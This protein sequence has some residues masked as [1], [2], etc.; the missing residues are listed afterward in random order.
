M[1]GQGMYSGG[2]VHVVIGDGVTAAAFVEQAQLSAG[3]HLVVIG[4]NADALGRGVAYAAET[5]KGPWRYAYL[6]NS[7]G[8]DLDVDFAK[9]AEVHWN[10]IRATM[11][12]RSPNWLERAAEMVAAGDIQGLNFPRSIYGDYMQARMAAVLA[13]HRRA[14]VKTAILR[15]RVVDVR[16]TGAGLEVALSGG[17]TVLADRVD[18]A[19]GAPAA[20]RF[21]GDDGA[22]SAPSLYGYE[23][24]I[25]AQVHAGAEVFCIG[26]NASMMDVLRLFQSVVAEDRINLHACSPDGVLPGVLWSP[27]PRRQFAP[28]FQGPYATA[29]D[30]LD[31]T[32]ALITEA[33][34]NG[35]GLRE[36]RAG[37]RAHLI[38]VGIGTYLLDPQEARRVPG[39]LGVLLRAGTRDTIT[40]FHRLAKSGQTKV[41]Q[42]FVR[43]IEPLAQGARVH[44]VDM[45]GRER[46]HDTGFV[47]NCAGTGPNPV[48]DPLTQSLIDKGWL[49][50][51]PITAGIV[52][53]P[54]GLAGAPTLR[55]LSPA[56]VALGN[57]TVPMPLYDVVS[58][59]AMVT[60]ITRLSAQTPRLLA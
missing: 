39:G 8:D 57:Q 3:D 16:R 24:R 49:D 41:T 15:D 30:M 19:P 20:Q 37:I 33:Q 56:T 34:K 1:D 10:D 59:R 42:A 47:V 23:D 31:H 35:L 13:D 4:P 36:I 44:L 58:L 9:W 54:G 51:C 50:Q 14:G 45:A 46:T 2:Q 29:R 55:Y 53:G 25:A 7:P 5:A 60:K 11:A 38:E 21:D 32:A 6:L 22:Y 26:T 52:T 40:D 12:G 48:Y 43:R 18:I 27:Q 17:E 28:G